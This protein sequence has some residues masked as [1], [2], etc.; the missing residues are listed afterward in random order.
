[1][2]YFIFQPN[3]AISANFLHPLKECHVA[4]LLLWAWGWACRKLERAT[5]IHP[6]RLGPVD[7][8]KAGKVH[9]AKTTGYLQTKS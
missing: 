5:I 1:M 6:W 3:Y 7:N 4:V 8:V 9:K 2:I